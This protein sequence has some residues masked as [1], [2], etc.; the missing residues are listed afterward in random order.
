MS[1]GTDIPLPD[2]AWHV[3]TVLRRREEYLGVS[4]LE[5]VGDRRGNRGL[6]PVIVNEGV[7]RAELFT[8]YECAAVQ[9]PIFQHAAYVIGLAGF[10]GATTATRS[11]QP[12]AVYQSDSREGRVC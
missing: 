7:T 2:R 1:I 11:P 6:R 4:L 5:P 9:K 10:W 3:S 12:S 8:V